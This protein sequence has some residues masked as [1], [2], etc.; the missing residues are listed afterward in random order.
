V[1]DLTDRQFERATDAAYAAVAA[2]EGVDSKRNLLRALKSRV[3]HALADLVYVEHQGR[4]DES[5][6]TDILGEI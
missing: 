4:R 2:T 1:S 5:I 3:L 6:I